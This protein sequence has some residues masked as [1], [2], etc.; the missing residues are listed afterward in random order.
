M[1]APKGR[2]EALLREAAFIDGEWV[3]SDQTLDVI[4]PLTGAILGTVPDL[5]SAAAKGAVA[6]AA[7][8]LADWRAHPAKERS[9]IL[10]DWQSLIVQNRDELARLATLEQ[11]RPIAQAGAEID[12]IA[13]DFKW[14][15]EP[16]RRGEGE[17]MPANQSDRR[18]LGT[19]SPAGVV[20]ATTPS[21][22]PP[23][24]VARTVAPA[25]AAG[26]TMVLNPSELAPFSALALAAL[27]DEAGFPRGAFNVITCSP[28]PI[29]YALVEDERVAMLTFACSMGGGH[30]GVEE[31]L[32]ATLMTAAVPAISGAG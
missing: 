14:V 4:S 24:V 6:A 18:L 23:L 22:V 2:R 16:P 17:I 11:G 8:A 26:C 1:T 5:G 3:T 10:R 9:G 7:H 19:R 15:A 29:E 27:A 30:E 28:K 21:H 13:A 12:S 31:F 32:K 20:G 25:L